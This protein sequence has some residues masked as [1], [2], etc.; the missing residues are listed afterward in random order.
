MKHNSLSRR[1]F[2]TGSLAA[3]LGSASFAALSSR[4]QLAMAQTTGG[5]DYKALVC[6]F[7]F[8]GNDSYNMIV[9]T[10]P[11]QYSTYAHVRQGLAVAQGDVL[12]MTTGA[13]R[14]GFHPSMAPLQQ[15]YNSGQLAVLANCGALIEPLDKQQY[16]N[17]KALLPPQLFS[18][19][20]QQTFVQS[21]AS[22]RATTGWG[23][24]A[25]DILQSLNINQQLSMNISLAGNNI[26][27]SGREVLPYSVS[28]FGVELLNH[29]DEHSD[30][31]EEVSR[32]QVFRALLQGADSHLFQREY[33]KIQQ[34]AW[35]LAGDVK[36]ALDAQAPLHTEFPES[37]LATDLA[38]VAR[39]ISAREALDVTRQIYFV[40]MGDYDTHGDQANRQPALF[41]E[42]SQGLSAFNNAIA[43]Q[44]L[45]EQVTAFTLS[46]FG[47]TL[48]SN[49]DGTDHGWGGHHLISGGAVAGGKIYGRLPSLELNSDDDIGEGRLIPTTGID[50]YG[51]T[52]AS[53][54]GL[55]TADFGNA[56][57][58]LANFNQVDLGFMRSR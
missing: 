51:A 10:A 57:P 54:F 46:D 13:H 8:G 24:R 36:S 23:G 41:N 52:L 11:S 40:G 17:R 32:A 25:A 39:L 38:M 48:I 6:I 47:R 35:A 15:L 37:K 4:M 18:H 34:R 53:W 42:L 16:Q 28:G 27:Q 45:A 43:E 12:P 3:C 20:D 50:Q 22:D 9:P 19:N 56:F 55:P 49:G 26:F 31:P 21:L 5:H 7:L 14:Y 1:G 33:A 2:L 29:F 44:G 30:N 58:N